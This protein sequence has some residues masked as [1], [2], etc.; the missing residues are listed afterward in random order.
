MRTH[1]TLEHGRHP[2][3]A[4]SDMAVIHDILD[5][6]LTCHVAIT[7]DGWPY[8]L[9]T[10]HARDGGRLLIHGSTLS[11]MLGGLAEGIPAC[12]TVT[13]VEG[14]VAARSAFHHSVNYRSAMVFGTATPIR[15]R[16]DKMAALRVIVEHVL[17]GRW[18]E[19]R[20]PSVTELRA[21]EIVSIP[22]DRTTAKVREGGPADAPAD[23][24]HRVWSGVIPI[25]TRLLTPILVPADVA[26]LALPGSVVAAMERRSARRGAVHSDSE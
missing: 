5:S 11:R 4:V 6:Q 13:A 10:V 9:P 7:V 8:A 21:T 23:L 12:V 14:I 15:E 25:E 17:P 26:G 18:S 20:E 19:V 3:R 1:P 24:K 22:L 16:S 2:E